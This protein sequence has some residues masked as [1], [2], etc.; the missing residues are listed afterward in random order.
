MSG[1]L[2]LFSASSALATWNTL[3]VGGGGF[4]RGMDIVRGASVDTLL[5]RSDTPPSLYLW[6]SGQNQWLPLFTNYSLPV[7][8]T[9]IFGSHNAVGCYDARVAPSNVSKIYALYSNTAMISINSGVSWTQLTNFPAVTF[10]ANGNE[11]GVNYKMAVDPINDAVCF[12]GPPGVALQKTADS[13]AT[14]AGVSTGQVPTST[15]AICLAFDTTSA[16]TGG[17]TQGLFALSMGHGV[18]HSTDGG[19]N[20]T[21]LNSTGMPTT[22]YQM[23]CDQNGK[24]WVSDGTNIKTIVS[25]YTTWVTNTL[26]DNP[27][28][29]A[30]DPANASNVATSSSQGRTYLSTNGGTSWTTASPITTTYDGTGDAVW[31][32]KGPIAGYQGPGTAYSA[33]SY[34][35]SMGAFTFDRNSA[36]YVSHGF[37]VMKSTNP[38]ATPNTAITFTGFSRGMEAL[39]AVCM[40]HPPNGSPI[41]GGWDIP[42]FNFP[43]Y[44]SNLNAY[45]AYYSPSYDFYGMMPNYG[46]P[47]VRGWGLDYSSS[48]PNP[49]FVVLAGSVVPSGYSSDAG[50][51]WTAFSSQT[52][53]TNSFFMA[54]IASSTVTN[55]VAWCRLDVPYYT[56]D[57]GVTWNTSTYAGNQFDKGP[58]DP[59]SSMFVCADRVTANKFY[60]YSHSEGFYRSTNSGQTFTKVSS[61]TVGDSYPK[62][63]C[64]PGNAGHVFW[65][66][67]IIQSGFPQSA[68]LLYWNTNSA[69][70]SSA[71]ATDL[72][73]TLSGFD[74]ITDFSFG[75]VVSGQTYPTIYIAAN[76]TSNGVYGVYECNNFNSSTGA[77]TWTL[78]PN[79]DGTAL[80][81]GYLNPI[82]G[83]AGDLAVDHRCSISFINGG[84]MRYA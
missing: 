76:K 11:A 73:N 83:V 66:P 30:V 9:S 79:S 35:I 81:R 34:G 42:V 47:N 4:M 32:S 84:F 5:A 67:G 15:Q 70:S 80:P 49:A 50:A 75:T 39:D 19:T 77:G 1:W 56:T 18:Y 37:G 21:L 62:F 25:P 7:L 13:G 57:N 71:G 53:F 36:L 82:S 29:I 14:W 68:A 46:V 22:V 38:F 40:L 60:I 74:T 31:I 72:W 61:F 33:G 78:M 24:L 27:G 17:K 54:N 6:N 59:I 23:I 3:R 52:P 8:Y 45:A 16:Q 28:P 20:F 44:S 10:D 12:A 65:C 63:K 41:G 58:F 55:H 48:A 2:P 43:N 69:A 26:T 64:A 51:T